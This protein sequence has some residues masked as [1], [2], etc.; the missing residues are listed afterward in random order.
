MRQFNFYFITIAF[1]LRHKLLP[2]YN[3]EFATSCIYIVDIKKPFSSLRIMKR[4]SSL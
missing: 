4:K 3:Y 1:F 2:I